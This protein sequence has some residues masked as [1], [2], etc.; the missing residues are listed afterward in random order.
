[1]AKTIRVSETTWQLLEEKRKALLKTK[2][3]NTGKIERTDATFEEV[4]LS[5]LE[6]KR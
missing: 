4:I 5:L 6:D 2:L 3:C 1:M